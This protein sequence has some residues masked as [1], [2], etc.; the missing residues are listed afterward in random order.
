MTFQQLRY[1]LEVHKTGS[2]SKAAENLF[3]S[4]PS[5]SLSISSLEAEL[6]YPLFIRSQNG[7][8]PSPQGQAVIKH[9]NSICQTHELIKNINTKEQTTVRLSIIKY[10]PVDNATIR[11]LSEYKDRNDVLFSIST[12]VN[13]L[14]KDVAMANIDLSISSKVDFN[15]NAVDTEISRW[16]LYSEEL[17]RVPMGICI[18]PGHHLYHKKD[19][20]PID[21]KHETILDTTNHAWTS[22]GLL[23][24]TINA[25]PKNAI[26]LYNNGVLKDK[27]IRKGLA[28]AIRRLPASGNLLENELRYLPI[29]DLHHRILYVVDPKRQQ[30]EAVKHYIEIL[31]EELSK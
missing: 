1:L 24:N 10:A 14:A 25:D 15:S 31:K 5:V 9:A 8:I 19:L 4:R 17:A 12:S 11:L 30:H 2:I 21:F 29:P 6:G 20:S 7:L 23:K 18:G 26:A 16:N 3:V 22:S 27:I 28:Y 13:T